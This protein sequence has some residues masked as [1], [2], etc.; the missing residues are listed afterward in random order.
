MTKSEHQAY[1]DA[2]NM[3]PGEA[4][5]MVEELLNN[6]EIALTRAAVSQ[7]GYADGGRGINTWH[8]SLQQAFARFAVKTLI[9]LADRDP[10]ARNQG[11]VDLANRLKQMWDQ[12]QIILPH[13]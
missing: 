8:P 2:R 9:A 4:L 7:T 10:D 13:I 12:N 11:A 6:K 5:K 1:E 3:A